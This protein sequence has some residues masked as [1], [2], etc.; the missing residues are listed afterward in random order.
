LRD[1]GYEGGILWFADEGAAEEG[2]RWGADVRHPPRPV[3]KVHHDRFF[4]LQKAIAETE[5]EGA[6]LADTRDTIFQKNPAIYLPAVGFHAF[7]EDAGMAIGTC[8]YNSKWIMDGFGEGVLSEMADVHISCVGTFCGDH[9]SVNA[10]LSALADGIRKYSQDTAWHNYTIRRRPDTYPN[11]LTIWP[12][13]DGE[14]YTVGY[15]PRG[16]VVVV[17][18]QIQNKAGHVP[19]VV[20][21]WDRHR[22]L[23]ALVEELYG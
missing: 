23:K 22:N 20:H 5:C 19:A 7:E 6:F 13:E 18:G 8:P 15:I 16:M 4:H 2:E 12:N 9:E 17:A 11:G 10:H 14:V 3:T 21:Q 1:V